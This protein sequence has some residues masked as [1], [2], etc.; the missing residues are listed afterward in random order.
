[1]PDRVA[2]VEVDPHLIEGRAG[3]I[4]DEHQRLSR[5][6]AEEMPSPVP[7]DQAVHGSPKD[8]GGLWRKRRQ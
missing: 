8:A 1:M 4:R 7:E 2:T 3:W 6:Y 5:S